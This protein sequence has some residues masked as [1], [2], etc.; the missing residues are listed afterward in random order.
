MSNKS[1][2]VII[3]KGL[4]KGLL[5]LQSE[6]GG[7]DLHVVWLD[8]NKKHTSGEPYDIND[9]DKTNCILHFCDK[10]SVELTID[11]LRWMLEQW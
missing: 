1:L 9:I 11:M 6:M 8:R 4:G 5:V 3:G 10:K 7:Y 2:P